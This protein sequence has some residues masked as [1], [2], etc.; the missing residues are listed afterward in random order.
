M[1]RLGGFQNPDPLRAQ[2]CI[3]RMEY[4]ETAAGG[5]HLKGS[6]AAA[7]AAAAEVAKKKNQFINMAAG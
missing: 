5:Q 4:D 3:P 1:Q 7:A 6:A 2:V